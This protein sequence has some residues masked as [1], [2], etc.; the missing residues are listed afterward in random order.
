MPL[1]LLIPLI[2]LA[3]FTLWVVLLPFSLWA[4][5]A[6]GRAR[7]RAV[8]WIVRSNAW[9][10]AV[11]V[12]VFLAS[13]W[14]AG[15]WV[16]DALRDGT[17]GLALGIVIGIVSSWSTRFEPRPAG[18]YYTPNRWLILGLTILVALRLL[19]GWLGAWRS[20]SG[21]GLPASAAWMETGGVAGIGGVLIGY[22]LAYAWGLRARLKKEARL[23]PGFESRDSSS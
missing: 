4:R 1:L 11:S 14:M 2:A 5:Y 3:V 16:D 20:V 15:R 19:A 9:L 8:G 22:A 6:H 18:L 17:I 12:P 7:R 13:A 23:A 21:E 10:L